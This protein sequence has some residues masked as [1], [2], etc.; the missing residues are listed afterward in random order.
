MFIK[1]FA[2]MFEGTDAEW[3][4]E[5]LRSGSEG[6]SDQAAAEAVHRE[7]QHGRQLRHLYHGVH[8]GRQAKSAQV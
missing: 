5:L 6:E 7:R 4:G 2:C 3:L 1:Y 8:G